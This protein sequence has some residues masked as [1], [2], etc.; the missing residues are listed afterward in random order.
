MNKKEKLPGQ[1]ERSF[2]RPAP[3]YINVVFLVLNCQYVTELA[4]NCAGNDG[5]ASAA[6]V[7]S[8]FKKIVADKDAARRF[9]GEHLDSECSFI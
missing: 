5:M 7:F 1:V 2:Q 8:F 4:K 9:C 6:F 3:S